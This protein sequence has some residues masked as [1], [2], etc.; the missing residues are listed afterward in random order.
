MKKM[1]EKMKEWMKEITMFE[2]YVSLKEKNQ[3]TIYLFRSGDLFESCDDDAKN[4]SDL[5][6]ITLTRCELGLRMTSFHYCCLYQY[7]PKI[8]RAGYRVNI[9]DAIDI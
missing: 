1:K 3:D 5:R 8:I 4:I 7:L 6:G 9:C 2:K